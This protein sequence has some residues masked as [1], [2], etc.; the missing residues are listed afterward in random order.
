[1]EDTGW[2]QSRGHLP[3]YHGKHRMAAVETDGN[4][5][6]PVYHGRHR[7]AAVWELIGEVQ[8]A[9][10]TWIFLSPGRIPQRQAHRL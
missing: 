5:H 3:V 1:M 8:I 4:Y 2:L 9:M 10:A 7:T 6:P